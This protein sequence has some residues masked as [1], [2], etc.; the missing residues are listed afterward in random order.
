MRTLDLQTSCPSDWRTPL[1]LEMFIFNGIHREIA[2]LGHLTLPSPS[3][4]HVKRYLG[5]G[6]S[7]EKRPTDSTTV[8]VN[9]L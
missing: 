2:G 6:Y 4:A 7:Q 8:S 1:F 3:N 9:H 5:Q